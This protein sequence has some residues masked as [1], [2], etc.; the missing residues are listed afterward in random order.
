MWLLRIIPLI[1]DVIFVSGKHYALSFKLINDTK[2]VFT[3]TPYVAFVVSGKEVLYAVFPETRIEPGEEKFFETKVRIPKTLGEGIIEVA[4]EDLNKGVIKEEL[5]IIVVED[6]PP[7]YV[8]FVWHHHQAPQFYPDGR[9]KDIWPFMHVVRG[10][11]YGFEGGPYKV[12]LD[13]HNKHPLFKDVDHLSPSLLYQWSKAIEEGYTWNNEVV[14][15]DDPRIKFIQE[16]LEG[17]RKRIR[18]GIIEPLGSV[19]AHTILGFLLRKAREHRIYSFIRALILWELENGLKIVEQILGLKPRGVWTPEMFWSME[20]IDIYSKLGIKYTVL[21]EQH[22]I[23]SGGERGTIYEPYVVE[24]P[25]SG[26]RLV[27]FFRDLELSDWLSFRVNFPNPKEAEISARKF[28]IELVKRRDYG[29][30]RIVVIALDGENWMI[31]P[32]YKKFAPYFLEKIVSFIERSDIIKMVTLSSFLEDHTPRRVLNYIPYGSWISLSD[33]QWTG[34][35]KDATWKYVFEKLEWVAALYESVIDVDKVLQKEGSEIY[36]AF[37]A[38]AIALD[39]DFYWYGEDAREREFVKA[40]AEEAERIA[41]E[42]FSRVAVDLVERTANNVT[43][44]LKNTTEYDLKLKIFVENKDYSSRH[45]VII[46]KGEEKQL[47]I[48]SPEGAKVQVKAGN[49]I[50]Q[51]Y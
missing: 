6:G 19:F 4:F 1:D 32:R 29:G 44:S 24:D 8:S 40:W 50:L 37:F 48:Y 20:V 31:L 26:N 33:S 13:V 43:I 7:L 36:K 45:E 41:K 34:G 35:E 14:K 12:H 9:Y 16:T 51:E 49:I 10:S 5:P 46:G 18:E 42:F 25:V 11:F 15:N 38:S 22:F 28:V 39:S 23:R 17:Y 47:L 30:D 27:I 21:C 3:G 2:E